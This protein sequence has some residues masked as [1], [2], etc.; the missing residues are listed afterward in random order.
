MDK[1]HEPAYR[2]SRLIGQLYRDIKTVEDII[3]LCEVNEGHQ[4]VELDPDLIFDGWKK[5]KAVAEQH[6]DSYNAAI[7]V[8]FRVS[9]FEFRTCLGSNGKLW[10]CE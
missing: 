7:R 2:S 6:L 5:Y 10:N 1:T 3:L 9:D 8:R 4:D